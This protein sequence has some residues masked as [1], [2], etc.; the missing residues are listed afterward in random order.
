MELEVV[1]K[2]K[3]ESGVIAVFNDNNSFIKLSS[4]TDH[5]VIDKLK[6]MDGDELKHAILS[7]N[8]KKSDIKKIMKSNKKNKYISLNKKSFNYYIN[9]V[10]FMPNLDIERECVYIFGSS[11]SGKS[12]LCYKYGMLYKKY[13]KNDIFLFS[14]VDNDNS[15][16][17]LTYI[18]VPLDEQVIDN[19]DLSSFEN[20]LVIFDDTDL[21]NDKILEKKIDSLK[22]NIAQRG[23]HF[24]ISAIFTTHIAANFNRTKLLLSEC[25]KF[26]IFPGAGGVVQQK[27]MF[28]THGGMNPTVFES[29]K[30]LQSRWVMFNI[31]YPNYIVYNNGVKLL[32]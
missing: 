21:P 19:I 8:I 22:N 2:I 31:R 3:N 9:D 4:V 18:H 26:V 27:R 12:T 7:G 15:L 23:R 13:K 30:D 5:I 28:I 6:K 24:K 1:K 10:M 25:H 14:L 32:T 29:L 11:G 16:S 17:G 20:S